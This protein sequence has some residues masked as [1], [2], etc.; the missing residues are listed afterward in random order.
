MIPKYIVGLQ[1]GRGMI[2]IGTD[3]VGKYYTRS[4]WQD[5]RVVFTPVVRV[6][7]NIIKVGDNYENR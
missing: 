6:G 2:N 5:G 1:S 3:N 7:E 4:V